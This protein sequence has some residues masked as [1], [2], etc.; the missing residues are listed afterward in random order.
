MFSNKTF[1][2]DNVPKPT[3]WLYCGSGMFRDMCYQFV[4][5]FLL[6][7]AQY[8]GI[9][10]NDNYVAMYSAITIIIV[11][12][13]LWDGVNDPIMGFIIEKFHF[14][15]GKYRPWIAIGAVL[16][17]ITTVLMFWVP[18]HGWGYVVWFAVFYF[19]WDFTYTMNDIA[20]WSVLPSLSNKE[21]TRANL[22]TLLS[23]FVS[24]GSF[25]AGGLVPILSSSMGYTISYRYFAL[26]SSILYVASQLIL[27]IF[28][29]EKKRDEKLEQSSENM[30]FSEIF[31]IIGKNSQVRS[32]IIGILLYYTGSTILVSLGL[33]YFYFNFGYSQA[34]GY[35][36]IFTVVY[37]AATLLG[38]FIYP[39]LTNKLK[40]KRMRIFEI[41]SIVAVVGYLLLFGYVFLNPVTFFPL[42]CVVG[43]FVFFSQTMICLILYCMIQDSI[44][45]NEYKFHERRESAVFSLRAFTAKLGSSIQQLVLYF[46][47]LAGGLYGISNTISGY[48]TEAI[49]LYG[50]DASKVGQLV[51]SQADLITGASNVSLTARIIYQVGFTLVP[52]I[53]M[54][55]CLIVIKKTYTITEE[56]H[57]MMVNEI[58]KRNQAEEKENAK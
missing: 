14:K 50:D 44:E 7:F 46:A 23:I 38:Q 16:S 54:L 28:M 55:A 35:Q 49:N 39:I 43:F 6:M 52:L 15:S 47:L 17:S 4:S 24:I 10:Q 18:V 33:N 3:K 31:T 34:G 8:C 41:C 11:V 1:E 56:S 53:L 58:N 37:A 45:Y 20:F 51:Q 48:E 2:G 5:M 27:C 19:L 32:S 25:A 21:K 36:L 12:L 22:T 40:M 42:M 13:R 29:K 9:G 26:I 57:E 30:K